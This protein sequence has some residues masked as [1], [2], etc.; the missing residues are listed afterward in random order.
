MKLSKLLS[1]TVLIFGIGVSQLSA[2]IRQ[3]QKLAVDQLFQAYNSTRSPGCALAII[4]HGKI[5]YKRGYGMA[6]LERNL[7][8]RPETV[9]YAGSISKQFVAACAQLLVEADKLDLSKP[10]QFYLEDFPNYEEPITLKHLIHHTSG[11]K[12]YF[13]LLE[14]TGKNYLNQISETE[15][16]DLIKNQDQLN[17]LPGVKYSY[18]N[19][20]YLMLAMIVE[21]VAEM[22]FSRF[23]LENIF[24]PLEMHHSLF[25]DD[26]NQL[27]PHRAFGYF[28]NKDG[29][30]ENRI[31]RFDLV[32]SGGLYTTVEDLAKWD[33]N[34]YKS[35]IGSNQF[36]NNLLVNGFLN[37]GTDIKYAHAIRKSTFL[38]LPVIG[39]SG[40]LG[41]YRAQFTQFP[42]QKF[43]VIILGNLANF[44]PEK[45]AY[46]I[47]EIFLKNQGH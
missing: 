35:K 46:Q 6:D 27:V 38:G 20:G 17:F 43:S 47:A 12:D 10:V 31:M 9:F 7:P 36:V 23:V 8:I 4:Q 18:S 26:V 2:Q 24:Q 42:E 25:L 45:K 1:C 30:V 41:G 29:I 28:I 5:I 33:A 37:D 22:P 32:G 40:S 3:D 19:S 39:H 11:I 44:T 16:Y 14:K 13:E 34:F 15:V 21:K